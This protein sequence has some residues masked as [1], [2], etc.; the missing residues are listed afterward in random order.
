MRAIAEARV[1]GPLLSFLNNETWM[2]APFVEGGVLIG[3]A[4]GWTDPIIGCGLSSAYRDARMVRDV[5]L[6]SDDWSPAAFGGY[7]QE[8]KERL[9]RLRFIGDI[10]TGFFA[11]FDAVGQ[12]R[13]RRFNE[14]AQT[15]PAM[16]AHLI[17]NLAGPESQPP[18]MFSPA[19]RAYLL[20]VA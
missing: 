14:K 4:G 1:G 6:G 19:H 8:R 18:Q 17:A 16:L 9:R 5:L 10:I 11:Q 20:D 15:E 3:D 12:A 7:A 13:R 2:E